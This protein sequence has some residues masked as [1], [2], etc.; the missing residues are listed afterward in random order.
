MTISVGLRKFLGVHFGEIFLCLFKTTKTNSQI[1]GFKKKTTQIPCS[2]GSNTQ[3][4]L[5]LQ[6]IEH[7]LKKNY[8]LYQ[9]QS[10]IMH[11]YGITSIFFQIS[12]L[13]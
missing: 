3:N 1:S 12:V 11:Y 13:H 7:Q 2:T 10:Y 9:K 5:L 4:Y 8:F 6:N